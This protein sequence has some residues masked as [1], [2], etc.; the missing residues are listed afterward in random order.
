MRSNKNDMRQYNKKNKETNFLLFV[1]Y[2]II[3]L[4]KSGLHSTYNTLTEFK[5]K[6]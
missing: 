4:F 1:P 3:L 6:E 2:S 5:R